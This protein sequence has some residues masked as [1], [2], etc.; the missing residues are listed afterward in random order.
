MAGTQSKLFPLARVWL[1]PGAFLSVTLWHSVF[2]GGWSLIL[3]CLLTFGFF[4]YIAVRLQGAVSDRSRLSRIR[5]LVSVV[6]AGAFIPIIW[7]GSEIRNQIFLAELP[8]FQ[9]LTDKMISQ[10]GSGA[11]DSLR[12]FP[13]GIWNFLVDDHVS[14]LRA[15]D[16]SVTVLYFTG[17][18]SAL[19]HGGYFYQSDDAPGP[20]KKMHSTMGFRRL[21]PKWYVW[22]G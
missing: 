7:L 9:A 10:D 2:R 14:V 12:R 8:A 6:A 5:L 11:N 17:D 18:S 22:G 21:A 13:P 15:A 19:H 3:C 4:V 1:Y 16:G 20:L